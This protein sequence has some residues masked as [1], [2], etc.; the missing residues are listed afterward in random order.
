MI[1][2]NDILI[3]TKPVK[4]SGVEM[5]EFKNS[6]YLVQVQPVRL[7]DEKGAACVC[8]PSRVVSGAHAIV[9][10]MSLAEGRYGFA[11]RSDGDN[12]DVVRF[13]AA[14]AQERE[15]WVNELSNLRQH[16]NAKR[17]H[18]SGTHCACTT[19]SLSLPTVGS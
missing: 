11:L 13:F 6:Y 5:Y 16:I 1:L 4:K 8:A 19:P 14:T 18:H 3:D 10:L 9:T 2:L 12:V 17:Q 7:L 15:K